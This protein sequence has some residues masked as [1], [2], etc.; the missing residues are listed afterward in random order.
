MSVRGR[1][2]SKV[3]QRL[4]LCRRFFATKCERNSA[5]G[6]HGRADLVERWTLNCA[7]R[8]FFVDT[9]GNGRFEVAP[10]RSVGRC[11]VKGKGCASARLFGRPRKKG[12]L[13]PEFTRIRNLFKF[14]G[15]NVERS[16]QIFGRAEKRRDQSLQSLQSTNACNLNDNQRGKSETFRN[17]A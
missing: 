13:L 12:K 3:T 9:A 14:F 16:I 15:E 8:N 11:H 17:I 6:M 4:C 7:T 10:F 5:F 2:R 1:R